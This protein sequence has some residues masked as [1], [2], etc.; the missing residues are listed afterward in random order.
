[1]LSRLGA[2]ASYWASRAVCSAAWRA[3]SRA[4]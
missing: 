1:L 3:W 4:A 2:V